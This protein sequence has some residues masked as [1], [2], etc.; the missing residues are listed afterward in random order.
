MHHFHQL[1][2]RPVWWPVHHCPLSS[3]PLK[4]N[5]LQNLFTPLNQEQHAFGYYTALQKQL[6]QK[7]QRHRVQKW[8]NAQKP[9]I[10]IGITSNGSTFPSPM[11][12]LYSSRRFPIA[13]GVSNGSSGVNSVKSSHITSLLN[14]LMNPIQVNLLREESQTDTYRLCFLVA[15]PFSCGFRA[16][17]RPEHPKFRIEISPVV[18]RKYYCSQKRTFA[19]KKK[20]RKGCFIENQSN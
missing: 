10:K 15:L 7:T 16:D 2:I 8:M 12:R 3:F 19:N 18:F 1:C 6:L 4:H 20:H 9:C 14:F 5:L 17:F 11:T 13:I